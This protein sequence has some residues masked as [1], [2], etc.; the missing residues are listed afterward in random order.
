[1]RMTILSWNIQH[2]FW[3]CSK[4]TRL[5]DLYCGFQTQAVWHHMKMDINQNTNLGWNEREDPTTVSEDIKYY[6]YRPPVKHGW[7]FFKDSVSKQQSSDEWPRLGLS[8]SLISDTSSYNYKTSWMSTETMSEK[9]H[10]VCWTT[11]DS[12]TVGNLLAMF[13]R[14]TFGRFGS[15]TLLQTLPHYSMSILRNLYNHAT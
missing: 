1:M 2:C 14:S 13:P 8:F 15:L 12:Y 6:R 11:S 5:F 10:D 4:H 3:Y 9:G 7:P